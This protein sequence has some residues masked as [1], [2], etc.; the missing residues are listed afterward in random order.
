MGGLAF[1]SGRENFN[2]HAGH[3]AGG[4]LLNHGYTLARTSC[5][6]SLIRAEVQFCHSDAPFLVSANYSVRLQIT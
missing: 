3:F 4:L 2:L 6:R 5:T 1:F